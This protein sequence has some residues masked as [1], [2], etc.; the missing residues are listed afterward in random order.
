MPRAGRVSEAQFEKG[1]TYSEKEFKKPIDILKGEWSVADSST[2]QR[3]QETLRTGAEGSYF[4]Q[5]ISLS[6]QSQAKK[7]IQKIKKTHPQT[8]FF[9]RKRG[10]YWA[11][12][13]GRFQNRGEAKRAITS[14]WAKKFPDAWIVRKK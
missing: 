6:T 3:K 14:V 13:V 8:S 10:N 11:V 9:I 4:I 12:W 7:F 2:L 1:L 5:I